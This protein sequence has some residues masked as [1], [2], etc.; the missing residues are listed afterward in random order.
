MVLTTL[1]GSAYIVF[2]LVI[3][4]LMNVALSLA[5]QFETLTVQELIITFPDLL[6][7]YLAYLKVS[8]PCRYHQALAYLQTSIPESSRSHNSTLPGASR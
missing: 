8:D 4:D 7:P 6:V 1:G 5:S 3:G 2:Y